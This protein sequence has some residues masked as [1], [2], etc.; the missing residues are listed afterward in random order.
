[1]ALLSTAFLVHF[2]APQFFVSK[3]MFGLV[4]GEGLPSEAG[5]IIIGRLQQRL[6]SCFKKQV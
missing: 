6:V 2:N 4:L 5:G 1:M 3:G